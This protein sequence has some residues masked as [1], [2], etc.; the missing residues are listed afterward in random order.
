MRVMPFTDRFVDVVD[1]RR[2]ELIGMG[3]AERGDE[4]LTG[5]EDRGMLVAPF[6]FGEK[7]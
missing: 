7:E 2:A 4:E 6:D 3:L 1:V 5:L